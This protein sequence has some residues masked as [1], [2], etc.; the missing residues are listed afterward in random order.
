MLQYTVG[1]GFPAS[2]FNANN[3]IHRGVELGLDVQLADSLFANGDR[4]QWRNAYT[5]SDFQFDDDTQ[6]G[7][8]SIAGQPPHFYQAELRYDHADGWFVAPNLE[9]ASKADVDFRNTLDTPGYAL[10]GLGA[11]YDLNEQV[12]LFFDGRNLLDQ[13]YIS[14][15]STLV[16][17]AGNTNVYYP[18]EGRMLYAGTRI[19]F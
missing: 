16:S 14:T 19:R 8:N 4:L 18:G 9:L 11:G 2:T 6:F 13:R 15:F 17:N 7:D 12:S 5:Y 10:L 1:P 3:T